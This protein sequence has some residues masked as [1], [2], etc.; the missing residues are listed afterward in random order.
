MGFSTLN[1]EP[2]ASGSMIPKSRILTS[3]VDINLSFSGR[4]RLEAI[5]ENGECL[6]FVEFNNTVTAQGI[7][8]FTN[9]SVSSAW[10]NLAIVELEE[11][12]TVSSSTLVSTFTL[13]SDSI[14]FRTVRTSIFD[15][16]PGT[17]S[18]NVVR[19]GV[20]ASG[21]I[22]SLSFIRTEQDEITYF[23]VNSDERL[24]VV[25]DTI[26]NIPHQ[27]YEFPMTFLGQSTLC[28]LRAQNVVDTTF[29]NPQPGVNAG[30]N[31][32]GS[33]TVSGGRTL[34]FATNSSGDGASRPRTYTDDIL[35]DID[36][37]PRFIGGDFTGSMAT[38]VETTNDSPTSVL[39]RMVWQP[40]DGNAPGG[41]GRICFRTGG[42]QRPTT[43]WN[44][45]FSPKIPKN[46]FY[47]LEIRIRLNF[48]GG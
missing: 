11:G 46:E 20:G 44:M 10:S 48:T 42:D 5:S 13:N 27:I 24:R 15:F 17:L 37:P 40:E 36:E 39:G 14:P 41:V 32:N 7:E 26:L 16:L 18:G 29:S 30:W 12:S 25:H 45:I 3:D 33:L 47:A 8:R 22:F 21:A 4:Y 38:I 1:I 19:V 2:F 31:L 6:R 34:R 9:S 23:P 28:S 35:S 43:N